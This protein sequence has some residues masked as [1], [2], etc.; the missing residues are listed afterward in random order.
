MSSEAMSTMQTTPACDGEPPAWYGK[1]P[2]A[3]D[4]VN[5]RLSHEL[6]GW[7]ERWL[8][9]GMAAM[10]QR[11]DDEL[12]RY[13]TVAP[14][15]NFLIPA[16][17]G[18]QCVQPGCLAPSCDRVGRYYPVIATLPMRTADY[19]SALPDAAD[20]FYW[21]V[22]SA[23]LDAIRHARAPVQLERALAKVR[24]VP[25]AAAGSAWFGGAGAG[26]VSAIGAAARAMRPAKAMRAGRS[27]E[28]AISTERACAVR[29]MKATEAIEA[30]EARRAV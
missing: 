29:A 17:A 19:W 6:A 9:Q 5:H 11:G 20:A 27:A 10:R 3:G 7:W 23:L 30:I 25:G 13:Y 26:P 24:L 22:G 28:R 14:V 2:G 21:Q 8:Q 18:A 1:I 4:F 16:G 12:A 15:W